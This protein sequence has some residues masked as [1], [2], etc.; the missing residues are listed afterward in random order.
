MAWAIRT[1]VSRH[2]FHGRTSASTDPEVKG[3]ILTLILQL[4]YILFL[5][6]CYLYIPTVK[7]NSERTTAKFNLNLHS[8][9]M[10]LHVDMTTHIY[11]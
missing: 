7:S 9:S 3:Q 10:G 4:D 6:I 11:S 2:I 8:P 5:H 1:N